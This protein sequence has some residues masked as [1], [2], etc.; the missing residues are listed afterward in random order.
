MSEQEAPFLP[1]PRIMDRRAKSLLQS[2]S[3]AQWD[4]ALN[5]A[6]FM[7]QHNQTVAKL[8]INKA[9]SQDDKRQIV[10][11][12]MRPLEYRLSLAAKEKSAAETKLAALERKQAYAK[13]MLSAFEELKAWDE[14]PMA[15][16]RPGKSFGQ[17]L[18]EAEAGGRVFSV[19]G[20][21]LAIETEDRD[22]LRR[23]LP[24]AQR[25]LLAHSWAAA[26]SEAQGLAGEWKLP[27]DTCLFEFLVSGK[28]CGIWAGGDS[29]AAL[30]W[31]ASDGWLAF[32]IPWPPGEYDP[33][34]SR[35]QR[36]MENEI[37]SA[38]IALDAEIAVSVPIRA[39]HSR[40]GEGAASPA[41]NY[42][43]IT[44][45]RAATRVPAANSE[46]G[47]RRRLHFRRGHWRHYEQHKTWIRWTLVG[48]P[49]L[50]WID[51]EYRL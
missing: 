18:A 44:L 29:V 11:G 43:V 17:H 41:S 40:R 49:D 4:S 25:F 2:T 45:R 23:N 33:D 42:H 12:L 28:R 38:C 51:K 34:T 16:Q 24:D 20:N 15:M 35:I 22:F 37:K 5:D 39:E 48:S 1:T 21:K 30:L 46:T 7:A 10:K 50:G 26:F 47:I 36:L 3:L 27:A 13:R 6:E 31:E 32:T 9:I 19:V 8:A 14:S